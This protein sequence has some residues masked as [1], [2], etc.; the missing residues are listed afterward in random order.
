MRLRNLYDELG[1]KH[2]DVCAF[3]GGGGKTS[4][5]FEIAGSGRAKTLVTTTT[6]MYVP[7]CGFFEPGEKIISK[8]GFAVAARRFNDEKIQGISDEER[9]NAAKDFELTLIEAD[10][11]KCKPLKIP[12]DTEP[13]VPDDTS[14][15]VCVAGMDALNKKI[16]DVCFRY[17]L[18][19]LAPE[20]YVDHK[21]MAW[22]I[23]KMC[24]NYKC[25]IV[26][27]KADGPEE[28]IEAQ[29]VAMLLNREV[30][31]WS[32]RTHYGKL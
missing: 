23:N 7:E 5:I 30:I 22:I 10:G 31:I 12:N 26:L 3:I 32:T 21:T 13:V 16:G 20:S 18:A 29:R 19:G 15:I 28:Y 24:K 6:K 9:I 2:G 1:L 27:N 11:A 25:S 4:L 14:R 17:S 8:N